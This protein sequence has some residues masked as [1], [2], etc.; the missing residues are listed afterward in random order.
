MDIHVL[1]SKGT[2]HTEISA[3][4]N[5]LFNAGV[6]N[7]NL[8]QLSS[9]VP[10]GSHIRTNEPFHT[11]HDSWGERLYCVIARKNTA[12]F[13]EQAWAGIG[14]VQAADGRGL[15]V[16]HHGESETT[17]RNLIDKSLSDMIGSR[18]I[19]FGPAQM[20]VSGIECID[21]PVCALV[22][23]TYVTRDWNS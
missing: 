12:V 7:F 3:F 1:G 13:G 17:V 9:V 14:W 15:F 8:V 22:V 23:A 5:A 11:N 18:D 10:P 20:V 16:E 21:K 2:G 19:E 6:H 4:D